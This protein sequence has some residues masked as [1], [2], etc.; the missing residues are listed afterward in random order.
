VNLT[1]WARAQSIHVTTAYR[2]YREGNLPVPA[3]KAGRL[4]LVSPDAAVAPSPAGRADLYARVSSHDQK[5]DLDRQ[6]ARLTTWAA[7][8]G[9]QVTLGERAPFGSLVDVTASGFLDRQSLIRRSGST[10]FVLWPRRTASGIDENYTMVLV[11]TS[12]GVESPSPGTSPLRRL[13]LG[14]TQ[15]SLVP[16]P[17]IQQDG[18]AR[19]AHEAA[20]A[21]LNAAVAGRVVYAVAPSRPQTGIAFDTRVDPKEG[22]CASDSRVLA[23]TSLTL[24]S[25]E[26]VGGE[27]VFCGLSSARTSTVTHELGHT[28]GLQHSPDER[29]LMSAVYQPG[30]SRTAFSA[31]ETLTMSLMM[32][33]RGGNR[34]P[35]N[36]RD[37]PATAT[38]TLTIV[39]R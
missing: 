15:V 22:L 39:C 8:A 38:S 32:E 35:D 16:S 27:L 17:E 37:L 1:E 13:R 11:Y 10:R 5:A 4:I 3:R 12:G 24:Q 18:Q 6:V 33:R 23:F 34:F 19:E 29:D 21:T 25:S 31:S 20:V 36:D 28:F 2:W 26:I 9:G 14:T 30:F 7:D